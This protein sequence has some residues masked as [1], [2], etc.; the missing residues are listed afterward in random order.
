MIDDEVVYL[1]NGRRAD[2][3]VVYLPALASDHEQFRDII[4]RSPYR[5]LSVCPYGWQENA[6]CRPAIPLADHLTILTAFLERAVS[7]IR[8]RRTVLAGFSSGADLAL[9]LPSESR[10]EVPPVDGILAL[11][12][13]LSMDTCFFTSRLASIRTDSSEG[14]LETLQEMSA[15]TDSVYAWVL[16]TPYLLNVAKRFHSDVATVRKLAREVVA[17]FEEEGPSPFAGWYRSVRAKG[18]AVMALFCNEPYDREGLAALRMD[19]LDAGVL[20]DEF[21][22]ADLVMERDR[23]H[24]ELLDAE[25]VAERIDELVGRL[26]D[27]R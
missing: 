20:G 21:D 7:R 24:F 4:E 26:R 27:A 23:N 13:N 15:A 10:M 3:L 25:L 12:P 8:P 1:D 9:R 5:G 22:D 14:M 2:V 17:P 16:L 18:I 19:H 6:E 11:G